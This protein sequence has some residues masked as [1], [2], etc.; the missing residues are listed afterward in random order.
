MWQQSG[1]R[2]KTRHIKALQLTVTEPT[3]KGK[4]YTWEVRFANALSAVEFGWAKTESAA[5]Q[6]AEEASRRLLSEMIEMLD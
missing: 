5:R 4:K 1:Y 2:S 6:E 3:T